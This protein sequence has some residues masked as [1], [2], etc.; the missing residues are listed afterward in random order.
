MICNALH[1][2]YIS[3]AK[4]TMDNGIREWQISEI[5]GQMKNGKALNSPHCGLHAMSSNPCK[6]DSIYKKTEHNCKPK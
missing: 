3:E 4:Y 5:C 6:F 1:S 2:A